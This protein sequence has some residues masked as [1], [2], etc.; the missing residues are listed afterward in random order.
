VPTTKSALKRMI[1]SELKRQKNVAARSKIRTVVKKTL[2]AAQEKKT[3]EV[4]TL[5]SEAFSVIDKAAKRNILH[6]NSA[7]RKKARLSVAVSKM[8]G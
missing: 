5:L 1:T 3:A 6:K 8:V 7:A 4:K 2:I